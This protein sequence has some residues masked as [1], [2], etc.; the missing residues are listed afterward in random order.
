MAV[1]KSSIVDFPASFGPF[2]ITRPGERSS[3][4][5]SARAPKPSTWNPLMRMSGGPSAPVALELAEREQQGSV[6][7]L[8]CR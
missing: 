5:N 2:S 1:K 6:N 3:I 4:P 8:A 7:E